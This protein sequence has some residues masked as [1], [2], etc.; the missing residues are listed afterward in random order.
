LKQFIQVL[1][2]FFTLTNGKVRFKID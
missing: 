2:Y 1:L